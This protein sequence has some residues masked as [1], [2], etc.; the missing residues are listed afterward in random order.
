MHATVSFTYTLQDVR[1]I[2]LQ[3]APAGA[4][5]ELYRPVDASA[6]PTL[7][8]IIRIPGGAREPEAL[9][10]IPYTTSYPAGNDAVLLID[11]QTLTDI[12]AAAAADTLSASGI[13]VANFQAAAFTVQAQD[14][15]IRLDFPLQEIHV[16]R[17]R[18]LPSL[19]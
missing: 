16:S 7:L 1:Q 2:L 4:T 3:D 19:A 10:W 8:S 17:S 11:Q 14:M 15:S 13:K 18:L 6:S 9:A 12:L 5:L